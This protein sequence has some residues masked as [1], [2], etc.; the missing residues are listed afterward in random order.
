[1]FFQLAHLRVFHS[2]FLCLR[3]KVSSVPLLW[4][5]ENCG[6]LVVSPNLS[7]LS[8]SKSRRVTQTINVSFEWDPFLEINHFHIKTPFL[9][10][11]SPIIGYACHSLTHWLTNCC[12]VNLVDVTLACED[13][14]SK[15]VDMVTV[16]NDDLVGNN[17]LQIWKLR[18]GQD[19]EVE[20]QTRFAA[21]VWPVFLCWCF[22]KV[23][24]LNFCRDSEARF[25]QVLWRGWCL[26]VILKLMQ[27]LCLNLWYEL[28][29]RVRCA[30]GNVLL[31]MAFFRAVR[32]WLTQFSLASLSRLR[33]KFFLLYRCLHLAKKHRLNCNSETVTPS[34][35][36]LVYWLYSR[37]HI[38]NLTDLT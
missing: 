11:P 13:A 5:T 16:A 23:M 2:Y 37:L 15:L 32:E 27:D 19:S 21:G 17:L 35:L 7:I 30:F 20:V 34:D 24:K 22:V 12:L 31:F 28:N 29:P 3:F 26:V 10:D 33:A 38:L 4:R 1:M 18:F 14:N 8:F 6:F 25:E 36:R 9:S